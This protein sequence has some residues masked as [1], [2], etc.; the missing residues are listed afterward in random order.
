MKLVTAETGSK[1]ARASVT[2]F[3]RKGYSLY[4]VDIALAEGLNAI[5]K[6]IKVYKDLKT[7]DA[8]PTIEDLTSIYDKLSIV[9]TRELSE[10]AIDIALN[11]NITIYDSL[12]IAA[13][14][15]LKATFYTADLKLHEVSKKMTN[16]KLLGAEE[17]D[18]PM[19]RSGR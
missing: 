6:H 12:Y 9:T 5:W 3:L 1:E 4:S 13:T 11:Q 18:G 2:E 14:T 8:K 7:E 19:N 17:Y 10:E 15:K 16:S